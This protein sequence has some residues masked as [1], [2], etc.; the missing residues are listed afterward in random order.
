VAYLRLDLVPVDHQRVA[1]IIA[2]R[3]PIPGR[4]RRDGM[5][6]VHAHMADFVVLVV[7]YGDLVR[8]LQ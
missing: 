5:L 7:E 4:P 6:L 2:D 1:L 3:I 8:L